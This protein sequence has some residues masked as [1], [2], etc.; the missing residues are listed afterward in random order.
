[1]TT[2]SPA[3]AN[4]RIIFTPSGREVV[5]AKGTTVLEAARQGGVD[6]DSVCAARGICGRC[7]VVPTLGRFPKWRMSVDAASVSPWSEREDVFAGRREM[8]AGRRL[9]CALHVLADL[10]VDVPAESQVHKQVVRKDLD[11]VGVSVDP[12]VDLRYVEVPAPQLGG[13]ASDHRALAAALAGEWG[14]E[15]IVVEP[16]VLAHLRQVLAKDPGTTVAVYQKRRVVAAWPGFVDRVAGVAIDVG[17][18]T[19]AGYLCD[20]HTGDVLA[21]AGVMNPQIRFGED[22]MSRVSYA[23]MTDGGAGELTAAV[24]TAVDEL[25]GRLA[26]DAEIERDRVVDIV[27]VGNPIMHHIY[28]GFDPTPL[29][30]APFTLATGDTVTVDGR[31]VDLDPPRATV[32]FGPC[33]AGHVGADTVG[34]I[35]AEGPHRGDAVQLLIDVGTNAEIVL[36]NRSGL[37]A[38]S[39]PT[40]P[41]LEGGEISCGMRA[42]AGAIERVRIDR[43]TLEPRFAVIGA[44]P[45][46]DDPGFEAATRD[47][48]IGGV[49]GSGIIE[50][51]GEMFLAGILDAQ[52]RIVGELTDRSEHIVAQGRTFAYVVHH[53]HQPLMITQNDVRAVQLAKAALR[54]GIDLLRERSGLRHIDT[55][56]LAGAFGS[57]IDPVYA[58]VLGLIPDGPAGS[59]T[60]AGNAS[61]VGAVRALLSAEQR[62]EMAAIPSLV[63]K[64]ETA[65]EPRFQDL[66]VAAMG[67]P[68]TTEPT[69]HLATMVDL[70]HAREPIGPP[71]GDGRRR[72][73]SR[74]EGT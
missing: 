47:L 12:V 25:V 42:A 54:A 33:I 4:A 45:W 30:V 55:V 26:R 72:R 60:S 36:G 17:S 59:A 1:M 52:G 28:L 15:D 10:V 41:A 8:V 5:V 67:F 22:L 34:A 23:M 44:E 7:Q 68:H 73:R 2:A 61:G 18:T 58:M 74:R 65:T 21:T 39:S 6:L 31:Y 46:S 62:K 50:V 16:L 64:I 29:G 43:D 20:L 70:P 38:A 71:A 35:L 37:F 53:G 9:G 51:I 14:L 69:P 27:L 32:T 66:L 57:H 19:I 49:C 3:P 13:E 48:S 11:L 56:R 24:R 63:T 40:G